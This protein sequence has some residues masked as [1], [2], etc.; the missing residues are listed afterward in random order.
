MNPDAIET[1]DGLP[2]YKLFIDG[3]WVSSQR[4]EIADDINPA[5]GEVFARVQQAGAE[6]VERAIAAAHRASES[7]GNTLASEREI[8]LLKVCD[9]ITKR[10]DEIRD[11]LI[12]ECGSVSGKAQWEIEYVIDLMRSTAGDVRHVFGETM[13][14]TQPG[15]LSLSV[16]RPLGV[17]AGIAPFN[18]PFLLSMKKIAFA[19]AAGNTFILKPSEETPISGVVIAD[20]FQE[21]ETPAGVLNVIPGVPQHIGET[22]LSDPRVRMITF[23]GSTKTGRYLAVEA[24]RNLKRFTLEMGGKSPLI[25]LQDAEVDYAVDAAAFGIYLHQGQVCMA[26]SKVIVE[27]PLYDAFA[28]KFLAK[29]KT[30]K[31]GDPREE[32][33]VVG[34]LIR[35]S[36]CEFIDGHIQDA[37]EKGAKL[38]TGGTHEGAFYQPTVLAG[39][40]PEMRIYHEETFGPVVSLISAEDSEEAL[41]IANDTTYGLSAAV[42]TN[43]LQKAL[44]I[45][46]RLES[47][48]VHVNDTTITDEPHVPFGGAKN[49][50]FGREGGHYSWEEMTEVKWIT[51]QMGQR[52][53]PF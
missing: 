33:T 49:S 52:Q 43:D 42:V 3:A 26:N 18:S 25:V 1:I 13:P 19:L 36:Q 7:W 50:G 23:T 17:I 8:L 24:A 4:N 6:E 10:Q 22:L 46:M 11:L 20:I 32:D 5:T 47:G 21:A 53:F 16:R 28:E 27:K 34:P 37:V 45:S 15:Q 29:T 35:Q 12:E 9:I 31:V 40:T 41:R 51:M 30:I 39:V 48:M 14:M 44:D 2:T 38:L